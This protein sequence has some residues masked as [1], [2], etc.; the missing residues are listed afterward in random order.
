M[1]N[2]SEKT[3]AA[4][5]RA[6]PKGSA[7]GQ[8]AK[9]KQKRGNKGDFHGQRLELLRSN[10]DEYL[11]KSKIG[12]TREF[13]P[14]LFHEYLEKFNWR[15]ALNEEPAPT[16]VFLPD[17]MLGTQELA[18]KTKAIQDIKRVRPKMLSALIN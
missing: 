17:S 11:G 15:L 12:K 1:D 4:Q 5:Q 16:D 2:S 3:T 13:W 8:P 14:G 9:E 6:T 7:E 18:V 10:M